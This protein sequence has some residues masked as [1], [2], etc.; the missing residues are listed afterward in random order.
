MTKAKTVSDRVMRKEL[1]GFIRTKDKEN[2]TEMKAFFLKQEKL[3]KVQLEIFKDQLV[4]QLDHF[5]D[6][7][8]DDY[9]ENNREI[10]HSAATVDTA[11][12]VLE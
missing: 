2:K 12:R 11:S 3:N 6:Y 5:L 1:D 8:C 9:I 10:I 7:F 4:V